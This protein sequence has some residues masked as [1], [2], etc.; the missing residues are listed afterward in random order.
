MKEKQDILLV[1]VRKKGFKVLKGEVTKFPNYA[2]VAQVE[3]H[4]SVAL[5]TDCRLESKKVTGFA[6]TLD[7]EIL[8]LSFFT[9]RDQKKKNEYSSRMERVSSRRRRDRL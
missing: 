3:S 9:R 6:L 5:G 7:D 8:H 1:D 4:P 2:S